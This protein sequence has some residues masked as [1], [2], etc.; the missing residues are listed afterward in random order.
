MF[1]FKMKFSSTKLTILLY[2]LAYRLAIFINIIS[3]I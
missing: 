2:Y 1:N 3:L